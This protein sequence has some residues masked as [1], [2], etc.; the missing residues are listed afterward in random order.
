MQ[1][2][3]LKLPSLEDVFIKNAEVLKHYLHIDDC[4][5]LTV[6]N[7]SQ[8]ASALGKVMVQ[9]LF[10]K[11]T[12]YK[13]KKFP[14]P[15]AYTKEGKPYLE[16]YPNFY[17]NISHTKEWVAVV[18]GDNDVGVDIEALRTFKPA[19]VKRFFHE[20]EYS[21][22]MSQ[23][24]HLQDMEF[25]LLWTLKESYVKCTGTGIAGNFSKFA[26][27]LTAGG[28][29]IKGAETPVFFKHYRYDELF[30]SACSVDDVFPDNIITITTEEI[31]MAIAAK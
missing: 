16:G 24:S 17:F 26:I 25:T 18:V 13:N 10:L 28:I 14:L 23:P 20:D 31:L 8:M 4:H 2:Y 6:K 5:L 15:F 29:I 11:Q 9:Y 21:F 19:V 3:L 27:A 12:K 1:I 22:L 30:I 7:S